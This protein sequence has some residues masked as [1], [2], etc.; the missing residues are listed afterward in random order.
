MAT[1]QPGAVIPKKGLSIANLAKMLFRADASQ[2]YIRAL[3]A[4]SLYLAVKHLGIAS[5]ADILEAASLEQCRLLFD[6]D[7]WKKDQFNEDNF[8][9]WLSVADDEHGLRLLQKFA[10]FV[11]LKIISLMISRHVETKTFEEKTDN[12]PEPGY[13]T[14]DGGFTWVHVK[15]EESTRNFLFSRLLALLFETDADLFYKL[16]QIPA[17]ATETELEE[18]SY[19]GKSKRLQSEGFPSD[20][21]AFE[22]NS[23][24]DERLL[25][26]ELVSKPNRQI[27]KDI[28]S[29]EPVVYDGVFVRPLADLFSQLTSREEFEGELSLIMN[30]A[31]VRWS[32]DLTDEEQLRHWITK[33]RGAINLGLETVM[34]RTGKTALEI[35]TALGLQKLYRI[36]LWKLHALYL[37]ASKVSDETIRGLADD[38]AIF[39]IIAGARERFPE[40]P[41]F[42]RSDGTIDAPNGQLQPGYRSIEHLSDLDAIARLLSEKVPCKDP[43]SP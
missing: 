19:Q 11:D 14:P 42:L 27:L 23:P 8:W 1:D 9:E 32:V 3:P 10:K 6:F 36:G 25:P 16:L 43:S 5:S 7:C 26:Q 21:Y 40:T 18:E 41:V 34:L 31:F 33:V 15:I 29:I 38:S 39:A 35:Y 2:D 17:V 20:E 37:Q 13:Y 30:A 12:P 22:L 28:P 24:L 4:Q